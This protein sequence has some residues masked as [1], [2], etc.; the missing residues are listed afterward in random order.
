MLEGY[1]RSI[2][3]TKGDR[4]KRLVFSLLILLALLAPLAARQVWT[5]ALPVIENENMDFSGLG[6]VLADGSYLLAWEDR[7][8]IVASSRFMRYSSDHQELWAQPL[9]LDNGY[10]RQVHPTSDGGFVVFYSSSTSYY[11]RI[12]KYGPDGLPL[13]NNQSYYLDVL[14]YNFTAAVAEDQLEGY[15]CFALAKIAS[16]TITT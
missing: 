12:R 9:V 2:H 10:V 14:D 5:Q 3:I 6:C 13:W 11:M 15:G 7:A 16:Y 4:M 1:L 8:D